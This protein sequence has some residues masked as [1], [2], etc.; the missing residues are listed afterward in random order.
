MVGFEC[1]HTLRQKAKG[2]KGSMALKLDMTKAYDMVEWIFLKGMIRRLG[3]SELWISRIMDCVTSDR[4]IPHL[5]TFKVFSPHVLG[6]DTIVADLKI[7][8]GEWIADLIRGSFSSEEADDIFG[9]PLCYSDLPDRLIWHFE[10]SESDAL[11]VVDA[12]RSQ[13]VPLADVGVIIHDIIREI[14]I[15]EIFSVAFV[16]RPANKIPFKTVNLTCTEGKKP[17]LPLKVFEEHKKTFVTL[18]DVEGHG[19]YIFIP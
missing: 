7:V 13:V 16:P 1:M 11:T 5:S 15:C 8:N 6:E 9:L 2:K 19:N 17:L 14:S 4:W 12:I 3:L 18:K 10:K